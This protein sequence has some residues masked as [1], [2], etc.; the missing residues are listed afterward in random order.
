MCLKTKWSEDFVNRPN[1][2]FCLFNHDDSVR[3]VTNKQLSNISKRDNCTLTMFRSFVCLAAYVLRDA[4]YI[5]IYI[6]DTHTP[7]CI[8]HNTLHTNDFSEFK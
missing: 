7:A 3:V 8:A 5:Y 6:F 1:N 4:I 2:F